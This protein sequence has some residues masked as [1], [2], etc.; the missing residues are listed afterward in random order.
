MDAL[1]QTPKFFTTHQ[2]LFQGQSG[3]PIAV[4]VIVANIALPL[5]IAPCHCLWC[6][7]RTR[8]HSSGCRLSFPFRGSRA[9]LVDLLQPSV[10]IIYGRLYGM[11]GLTVATL[12]ADLCLLSALVLVT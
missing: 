6:Q 10:V 12:M 7:S 4:G 8:S 1:K 9:R 2:G 11:A 5:S 3:D